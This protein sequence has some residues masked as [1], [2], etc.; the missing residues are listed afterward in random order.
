V[1]IIVKRITR[2][3]LLERYT[4]SY[5]FL[6]KAVVDVGRGVMAVDAE[7]HAD[8]EALLLEDG[9]R[10]ENLWGVNFR[11]REG[12]E[13]FIA[14]SS[15]INMRPAQRSFSIDIEDPVLQAAIRRVVDSLVDYG[16]GTSVGE[17]RAA[18]GAAGPGKRTTATYP[19]YKHHRTLTIE[20]WRSFTPYQRVLNID[21]ELSRAGDM[22]PVRGS[23]EPW[24]CYERT[25][26]L[27]HI[28]VESARLERRGPD[29]VRSLL[30]L[31]ERVAR[32]LAERIRD[33]AENA[34]IRKALV[35]L[36]PGPARVA[37]EVPAPR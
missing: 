36:E 15:L 32:L 35:A 13:R 8:L 1:E 28:T 12:P 2:A 18:Y 7:W 5:P 11:L 14:Y 33:T 16:Q 19:R 26:E 17:P 23:Q 9:S 29:L 25:L 27:L 10:Q 22:I 30:R 31:R 6:T 21:C 20:R 34:A 37:R 3:E 4:T 24:D